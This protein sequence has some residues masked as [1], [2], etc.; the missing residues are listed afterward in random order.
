MDSESDGTMKNQVDMINATIGKLNDGV[1]CKKCLNKGYYETIDG[2]YI[3]SHTCSCMKQRRINR[4]IKDSG[5]SDS[6]NKLRLDNFKTDKEYQ[7][8]AKEQAI[9]FIE[10]PKW[11]VMSGQVGSGK[12]HIC[13]AI[14]KALI[15]KGYDFKYM[16]YAQDMPR[17]TSRM[18]SGYIDTKQSAEREYDALK[19]V[20]VLYIDDYLKTFNSEKVFELINHRYSEN[21]ITIIST[22]KT[23]EEQLKLDEATASR[24]FERCN[25]YWINISGK[26]KNYRFKG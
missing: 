4:Q 22:E 16:S 6:F 3:E 12:T 9:K 10:N 18:N 21:L 25:G 17:I 2:V 24:I 11:F 8:H 7:K 13:T 19:Q 15:D 5:L 14:S 20:Q 1:N 23:L 26:E